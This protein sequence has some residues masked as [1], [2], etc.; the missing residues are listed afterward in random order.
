[1]PTEEEVIG[2]R[3]YAAHLVVLQ[4]QRGLVIRNLD[5]T[6]VEEVEGLPL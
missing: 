3:A 6:N 1:M 5:L 2:A 4:K